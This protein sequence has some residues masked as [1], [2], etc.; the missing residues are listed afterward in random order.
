MSLSGGQPLD[1]AAEWDGHTL[2]PLGLFHQGRY[3]ALT[4]S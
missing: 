4:T 1:V 2:R 3:Q